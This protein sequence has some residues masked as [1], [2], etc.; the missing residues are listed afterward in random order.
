MGHSLLN[1]DI[2]YISK[3]KIIDGQIQSE[4]KLLVNNASLKNTKAGLYNLPL[5]FAFFLLTHKN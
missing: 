5:K 1:G 3:S 4:N 2:Y